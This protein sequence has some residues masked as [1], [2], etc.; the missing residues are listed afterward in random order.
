MPVVAQAHEATAVA[1]SRADELE[2]LAAAAEKSQRLREAAE[3]WAQA[4]SARELAQP[5]DLA[6]VQ[7]AALRATIVHREIADFESARRFGEKALAAARSRHGESHADVGSAYSELGLVLRQAGDLRGAIANYEKALEIDRSVSPGG[8]AGTADAL[9][10]LGVALRFAGDFDRAEVLL[11]ESLAIYEARHGADHPE[12]AISLSELGRLYSAKGDLAAALVHYQRALA[13]S[14]RALGAEHRVVATRLANLASVQGSLGN[15]EEALRL[16]ERSRLID[17]KVFGPNHPAAAFRRNLIGRSHLALGN[18]ATALEHFDGALAIGLARLPPNNFEVAV[19]HSNRSLALLQL[20]R[21][22]EALSALLAAQQIV[23]KAQPAGHWSQGVQLVQLA[24]VRLILG[25]PAGAERDSARALEIALRAGVRRLEWL[26]YGVRADLARQQ[27]QDEV[28]VHWGKQAVNAI[29]RARAGLTELDRELQRG[30]L[31]DKRSVY[32]DLAGVLIQLGRLPE[33]EGVMAMLRDEEFF[34]F[35]Q[36]APQADA[37]DLQ[38]APSGIREAGALSRLDTIKRRL[39]ETERESAALRSRSRVGL[40]EAEVAR[41]A[42]LERVLDGLARELSDYL[43]TLP[44]QLIDSASVPADQ[45]SAVV[46]VVPEGEARLQYVVGRE[47]VSAILTTARGMAAYT[48]SQRSDDLARRVGDLRSKLQQRQP[49]LQAARELYG[50]IVAPFEQ[51]LVD[52]RI[53]HLSI[54]ADGV[55][56]Y[57]PFAALHDGRRYLVERVSLSAQ[58]TQPALPAPARPRTA[59]D[60]AGLGLTREQPGFP[61]LPAVQDEMRAFQRSFRRSATYLDA[62]F[63]RERLIDVFGER[64]SVVHIASHFRFRA[65][66]EVHSYLLLGDGSRMTLRDLRTQGFDLRGVELLTLSACDTA[67]G[68]GRDETGAEI[69]GLGVVL[70][71]MGAASVLATLWPIADRGAAPFMQRLYGQRTGAARS[72]AEA[73]QRAQRDLLNG[74]AGAQFRH[75]YFWAGYLLIGR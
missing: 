59:I 52:G 24:R 2:S 28:A 29:Q 22:D 63:T 14:E 12:V 10:N 67:V 19:W 44:A 35:I 73:L 15:H 5:A 4:V 42:E 61:A 45:Q 46:Q 58:P 57:L 62:Q 41:R 1:P 13:I 53:T 74:R 26:A 75:P 37:R 43:A 56:R 31:A 51:A 3:L 30:F 72:D 49:D 66:T 33:A 40:S 69:D 48:V 60:A 55:L 16:A 25:D 64:P 18:A 39:A 32:T 36:R 20:G 9:H 65:G 54:A 8:N 23:E 6:R 68:G 34:D 7:T 47:N 27:G 38:S 70:Q 21:P 50:L 17:E 71:R 11:N